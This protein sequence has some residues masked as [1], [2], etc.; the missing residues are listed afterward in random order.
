[1]IV[2]KYNDTKEVKLQEADDIQNGDATSGAADDVQS[3]QKSDKV[4]SIN[5]Q[6]TQ[7][8]ANRLQKKNTYHEDIKTIENQILQ[9]QKQK[10][11]LGEDVDTT[12]IEEG[13]SRRFSKALFE[14]VLNRTQDMTVAVASAFEDLSYQP[15][16]TKCATFARNIIAFINTMED[17]DQ[18]ENDFVEFV[19]SYLNKSH[20]SLSKSEKEKFISNLIEN[21]KTYPHFM[22]IFQENN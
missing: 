5:N 14:G 20:I 8:L 6:I 15:D 10:A 2:V 21:M 17:K 19:E 1:M 22:W 18:T 12:W 11:T 9:L 13:V 4:T 7:L 3:A 16:K